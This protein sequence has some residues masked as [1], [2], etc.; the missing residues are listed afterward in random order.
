MARPVD[1]TRDLF[2]MVYNSLY[3]RPYDRYNRKVSYFLEQEKARCKIS[4]FLYRGNKVK[5]GEYAVFISYC[6]VGCRDF[7]FGFSKSIESF[8][9]CLFDYYW[10]PWTRVLIFFFKKEILSNQFWLR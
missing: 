1:N 4:K 5:E 7:N 6:F 2:F 9:S 10:N 3:K 8:G